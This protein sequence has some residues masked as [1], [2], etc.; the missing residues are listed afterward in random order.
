MSF[1][2]KM[3]EITPPLIWSW[4][5]KKI[6]KAKQAQ[7]NYDP[8]RWWYGEDLKG[9][10]SRFKEIF[11]IDNFQSYICML[12]N[13]IRDCI[14]VKPNE[15]IEL[16][17]SNLVQNKNVL[18]SFGNKNKTSDRSVN[19]DYQ[20]FFDDKKLIEIKNPFQNPII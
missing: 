5:S 14:L 13:E 6:N 8:R 20:V 19:G 11:K 3:K 10:N 2:L 18:L 17:F 12:N 1:K 9:D 16:Q 15:V 7:K 4:L